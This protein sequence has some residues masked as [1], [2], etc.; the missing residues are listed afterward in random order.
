MTVSLQAWLHRLEN[1]HVKTID[2]S[3][4]RVGAVYA[5]M[6]APRPAREVWTVAGT[7]GKGSVVGYLGGM[8]KA[9]GLRA[10]SF[11]SPHILRF[12]ERI[13]IDGEC[14]DDQ[15]IIDALARVEYARQDIS[16]TY[17]EFTTLASLLIFETAGLDAAVLEV[18]LGGRLDAVNVVDADVAVLTAIG[19]DHQQ[20]LGPDRESIG[21]EKAGIIRAH[22]P[23][24]IGDP[25]PPDSVLRHSEAL[26]AQ[27]SVL[28]RDFHIEPAGESRHLLIQLGRVPLPEPAMPGA[29]QWQNMATAVAA[30]AALHPEVL[31]D[32]RL[33]SSGL[34]D[35]QVPGRLQTWPGDHRILL[36]VGHNALAAEVIADYLCGQRRAGNAIFC[37]LGMLSD[38]DAEAVAGWLDPV[39]DHWIC[40]GLP[41]DRGQAGDALSRRLCESGVQEVRAAYDSVAEGLSYALNQAGPM[42]QILVF[43]S[44]ETISQAITYLQ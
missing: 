1:L 22:R 21:F 10:G 26:H 18:G 6:G 23:V 2:L 43:G 31:G 29:H 4:E 16:L 28:G 37:V 20:F 13:R 5:R 42:D 24:I 3:L 15:T 27:V 9:M 17:F 44:F 11:T 19:L 7:N 14:V 40:V 39:I 33:L 36:D 8:L 25:D 12:N 38:K 41:G 32:A 35:V 30:M 34:R